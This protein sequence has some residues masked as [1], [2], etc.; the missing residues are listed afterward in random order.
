MASLNCFP[1]S[2]ACSPVLADQAVNDLSAGDASG[3]ID[4]PAGL[5]QRGSLFARLMRPVFVVMLRILGQDPPEVPFTVDQQ[6]IEALAP[7]RSH[8]PLRKR[9]GPHRQIHPIQMIGTG[10][11]G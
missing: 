10:V 11:S 3:H 4:R 8:V 2:L 7:Q 5:V 6:V 1:C 9:I